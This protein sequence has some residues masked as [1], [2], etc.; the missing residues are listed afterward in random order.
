ML[1][2]IRI[3]YICTKQI[4]KHTDMTAKHKGLRLSLRWRIIQRRR[5]RRRAARRTRRESVQYLLRQHSVW[6]YLN[7]PPLPLF[8]QLCECAELE[9][10][11]VQLA[12]KG[13][14]A[15]IVEWTYEEANCED[16]YIRKRLA[17]LKELESR[18]KQQSK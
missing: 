4:N 9:E 3:S 16:C 14:I 17:R 6:H 15:S 7:S 12:R 1:L 5:Q 18:L 11:R 8:C 2:Y 13:Y 10:Y